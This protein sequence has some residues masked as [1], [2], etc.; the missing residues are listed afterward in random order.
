MMIRRRRPSRGSVFVVALAAAAV[1]AGAAWA[2]VFSN[3][4]PITIVDNTTATPYPSNITAT[5]VSGGLT[6]ITATLTGL[7]HTFL[8]DVDVLL[9]GPSGKTVVLMSDAGGANGVT[10]INL[11][12]ADSGAT[13]ISCSA[14]PATNTTYKPTNCVETASTCASVPPDSWPAP[15]PAGPYGATMA[16][17]AP[18]PP[19]G[20]YKL[21]VVDDCAGDVG[22]ISGGWSI[23]VVGGGPPTAVALASFGALP[24]RQHVVVHWRTVSEAS[25]LGFNVFRVDGKRTA[26]LNHALIPAKSAATVADGAYRLVDRSVRPGRQYTYR[27]QAVSLSGSRAWVGM[28]AVRIAQ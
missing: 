13:N 5:G 19:D 4:A 8:A 22:M 28:S 10:G 12:F 7:T 14:A 1:F 9:V 25:L 6:S 21:Y 2:T 27:L 16:A 26:R 11:T 3:P 15:A 23:N 24:S 17:M 18:A 20:T